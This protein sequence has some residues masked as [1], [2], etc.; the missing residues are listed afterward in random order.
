MVVT[1]SGNGAV[2]GPAR[3]KAT[4]VAMN[5]RRAPCVVFQCLDV[6]IHVTGTSDGSEGEAPGPCYGTILFS[7]TRDPRL[8]LRVVICEP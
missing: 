2:P 7:R 8:D 6:G 3:A 5:V 4:R 1:T